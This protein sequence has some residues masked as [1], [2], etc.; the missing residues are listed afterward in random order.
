MSNEKIKISELIS[1]TPVTGDY[2]AG[3]HYVSGVPV[4]KKFPFAS[5][6]SPT[7]EQTVSSVAG[8]IQVDAA[9]G[10]SFKSTLTENVSISLP[11]N[12]T[13]GLYYTFLL[14]QGAI[15]YTVAF[16]VN[17]N[18]PSGMFTMVSGAGNFGILTFYCTYG[19][20]YL[21]NYLPVT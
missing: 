13:D 15:D 19:R 8:V 9:D 4:T 11:T 18:D 12:L 17:V 10:V 7:T 14:E 16:G 1:E 2:V 3:I 6:A 20:L 21:T 5:F